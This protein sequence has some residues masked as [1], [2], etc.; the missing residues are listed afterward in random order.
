MRIFPTPTGRRRRARRTSALTSRWAT[1]PSSRAEASD[2]DASFQ[3]AF[4]VFSPDPVEPLRIG[5]AYAK[6]K[7]YDEAIKWDDKA[8]ALPGVPDQIKGL[9]ATDK[10][11]WQNAKK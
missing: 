11:N 9:A 3:K 5:R 6:V 10:T 7:N 1:R 2:A 4:D 8:A